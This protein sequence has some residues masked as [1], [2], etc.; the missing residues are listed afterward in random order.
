MLHRENRPGL[1]E[2][3]HGE[4]RH[5]QTLAIY[6]SEGGG[7]L[8]LLGMILAVD[9]DS[10]LDKAEWLLPEEPPD[11]LRAMYQGPGLGLN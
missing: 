10:P 3:Y 1:I 4:T 9:A 11:R 6:R 8:T 2:S 5:A 7:V